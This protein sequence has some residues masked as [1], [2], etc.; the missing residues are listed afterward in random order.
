MGLVRVSGQRV[1]NTYSRCVTAQKPGHCWAL[2][3]SA[4]I[5]TGDKVEKSLSLV[6]GPGPSLH[7]LPGDTGDSESRSSDSYSRRQFRKQ[8][9]HKR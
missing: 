9:S 5:H 4:L 1:S 3:V 7:H 8:H 2:P 6:A